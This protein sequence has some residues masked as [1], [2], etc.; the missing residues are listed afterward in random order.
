MAT[1]YGKVGTFTP[2]KEKDN[3]SDDGEPD[4]RPLPFVGIPHQLCVQLL[5]RLVFFFICFFGGFTLSTSDITSLN[6]R[7]ICG[8][9]FEF[10]VLLETS[11]SILFG[12]RN[13]PINTIA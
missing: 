2:I 8:I 6:G 12:I 3:S 5:V 4:H 10:V 1:L 13:T 9:G 11:C 7:G